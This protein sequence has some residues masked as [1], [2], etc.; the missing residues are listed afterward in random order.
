MNRAHSA[1]IVFF[2]I[3][4]IIAAPAWAQGILDNYCEAGLQNNLTIHRLNSD[5]QNAL[6]AFT[7]S[8]RTAG[9]TVD[10]SAGYTKYIREPIDLAGGNTGE[11]ADFLSQLQTSTI[12]NGKFYYPNPNQYSSAIQLTQNIYNRQNQYNRQ[13][14]EESSKAIAS[15]LDDFKTELDAQIRDAYFQYLQASELKLAM[16]RSVKIAQDNVDGIL[17]QISQQKQTKEILYR[18]KADL[19]N[20]EAQYRDWENAC[21]KAQ[22][23]FNFILNRSFDERIL[24]DSA[25]LFQPQHIYLLNNTRDTAYT[26]YHASYLKHNADAAGFQKRA[27]RSQAT[28]PVVQLK[29]TGGISGSSIN[30]NNKRL[31]YSTFEFS[32]KWNLFSNGVNSSR[33][34]QA[35]FQQQ[36]LEAQYNSSLM[37]VALNER[38]AYSDIVTHLAN[39]QSSKAAYNNADIY[40][41]AVRS[42]FDLQVATILELLDAEEQL[43]QADA[44]LI[45]W[46][47]NL[48]FK[49]VGYQKTTGKKLKLE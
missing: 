4:A 48:Q 13:V 33:A 18:A 10:F 20:K 12:K 11:I 24:I 6:W 14:K 17:L 21:M 32:L 8:K 22:F 42:K 45:K 15:Q 36:S 49:L 47:Y 37:Q 35:Y 23:N 28:I 38:S 34:K 40:F 30:F 9:P 1:G 25:Y 46:Y 7:E 3:I 43:R 44:N 41:R 5:Y 26:G 27:I 29:A 2:L 16:A 31:P 19:S 39:Y